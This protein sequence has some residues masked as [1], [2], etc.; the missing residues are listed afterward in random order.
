MKSEDEYRRTM[1]SVYLQ[2]SGGLT[3]AEKDAILKSTFNVASIP[4]L[5]AATK[6]MTPE[7]VNRRIKEYQD[8]ER[9][10]AMAMKAIQNTAPPAP[11]LDTTSILTNLS[12]VHILLRSYAMRVEGLETLEQPWFKDLERGLAEAAV[13][14]E[15]HAK[16]A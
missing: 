11:R 5:L 7:E 4:G 6:H 14:V 8:N 15:R 9:S 3:D 13:L 16:G 12:K 10:K 2:S 1:D